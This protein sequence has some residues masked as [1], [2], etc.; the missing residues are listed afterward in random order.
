MLCG[1]KQIFSN[2]ADL[3]KVNSVLNGKLAL[4]GFT[5]EHLVFR[6]KTQV[7]MSQ[8]LSCVSPQPR[9]GG[10]GG[11]VPGP[12]EG[13]HHRVLCEGKQLRGLHSATSAGKQHQRIHW[14]CGL[15][16]FPVPFPGTLQRKSY[17][18]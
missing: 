11:R 12:G 10:H 9:R 4:G 13:L 16:G 2:D 1:P 3:R 14:V 8:L 15:Q 5:H 17:F 6:L 18:Y 7:R